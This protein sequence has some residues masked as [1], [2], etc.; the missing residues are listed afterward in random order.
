M[1]G[2]KF[3][4]ETQSDVGAMLVKVSKL[5]VRKYDYK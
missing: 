5:I 3:V 1:Q 2:H 4:F